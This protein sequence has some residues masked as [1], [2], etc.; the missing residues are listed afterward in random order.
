M[1]LVEPW[2]VALHKHSAAASWRGDAGASVEGAIALLLVAVPAL[3]AVVASA[4]AAV[5]GATHTTLHKKPQAMT[6]LLRQAV[7]DAHAMASTPDIDTRRYCAMVD[8]FIELRSVSELVRLPLASVP[9][10]VRQCGPVLRILDGLRIR[11]VNLRHGLLATQLPER[12]CTLLVVASIVER[13]LGEH[14]IGQYRGA[15]KERKEQRQH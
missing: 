2:R 4:C 1:V 11:L 13:Q 10:D 15:A 7:L 6:A 5:V 8:V 14:L 12:Q 9:H 3:R